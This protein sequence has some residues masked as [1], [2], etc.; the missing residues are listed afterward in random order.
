MYFFN[1][2]NFGPRDPITQPSNSLMNSL[3]LL[4]QGY[5]LLDTVRSLLYLYV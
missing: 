1:N 5:L 2:G 4:K 3:P